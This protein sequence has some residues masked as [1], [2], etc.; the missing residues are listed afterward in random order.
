MARVAKVGQARPRPRLRMRRARP[1]PWSP[2]G[3]VLLV[4]VAH[5]TTTWLEL[6]RAAEP[7]HTQNLYVLYTPQVEQQQGA[8]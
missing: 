3:R 7:E 8:Y 6:A 2:G 4:I 5:I 1:W